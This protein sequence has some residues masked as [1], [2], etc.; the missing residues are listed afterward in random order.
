MTLALDDPHDRPQIIKQ[1]SS[2]SYDD[3]LSHTAQGVLR[4][5]FEGFIG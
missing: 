2:V 3:S 1:K 5:P 4:F